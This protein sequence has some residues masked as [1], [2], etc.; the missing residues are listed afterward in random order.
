LLEDIKENATVT[1]VADRIQRELS[2]PFHLEGHEIFTAASIG[3]ALSST[4][5]EHPEDLL[6]DADTA[7][8]R[9]KARGRARYEIF[10]PGMHTHAVAVLQIETDLRRAIE[11]NELLLHYQP[12]VSLRLQRIIGFEALL[13]WRH[14]K[15]GMVSPAEFIPI[16]EETGQIVPIGWWVLQ[17]ACQQMQQWRQQFPN[18]PLF[19]ISVNLSGRQF[20]SHLIDQINR[21]LQKTGLNAQHLKLEITESI[22]MESAE[23]ASSTLAQLKQLGIQ[24]AI[25]DFGTGYSSLSYLHR[26]P[27]D[28]LKIDR[29]FVSKLDVDGEQLAIVRTI[30]TLAWNLGMDVV[31]EGV[32]TAKQ[33]AQVRALQC[34]YAQGYL[35]SKPLTPAAVE[36]LLILN[37]VSY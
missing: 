6:R 37:P 4:P 3:I 22:L 17:E 25:D 8:Y 11:R 19:T 27:I 30:M 14:A 32:E 31:A 12:I 29:S 34:E 15:R 23:S 9:A 2:I 18:H 24:L 16:A 26:F 5:Y 20:T 28:C 13:R 21:T 7:M 33:L 1:R 36:Q 35:F 10:H